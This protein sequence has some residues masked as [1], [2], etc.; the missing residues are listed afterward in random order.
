M[1]V[2][3]GHVGRAAEKIASCGQIVEGSISMAT[4]E[5]FIIPEC[6]GRV[7]TVRQ[8][9]TLRV[10][11]IEGVQAADMIAF[12]L[13]DMKESFSAWLTRQHSRNFTNA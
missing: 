3:K 4:V 12:N 6:E 8:G 7:F 9:Q 11:E 1:R 13:S 5:E 10:I 2:E